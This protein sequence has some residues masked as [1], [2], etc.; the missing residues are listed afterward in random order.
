MEDD[1]IGQHVRKVYSRIIKNAEKG[2]G[3]KLSKEEV[4][5]LS[6]DP[7]VFES[8]IGEDGEESHD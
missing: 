8:L 4:E 5:W 3:V 1:I 6:K 2:V 7:A